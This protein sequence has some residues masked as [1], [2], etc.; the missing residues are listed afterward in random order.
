MSVKRAGNDPG[1]RRMDEVAG[2]RALQGMSDRFHRGWENANG[3]G[4]CPRHSQHTAKAGPP[5]RHYGWA[6]S[7]SLVKASAK[8][9]SAGKLASAT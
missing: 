7:A 1:R 2:E 3:A 8:N 9:S 5:A 4:C 6:R